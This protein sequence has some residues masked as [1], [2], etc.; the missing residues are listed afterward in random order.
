M[1]LRDG[2]LLFHGS[3]TAVEH[4]DLNQCAAGKDF[5]KGFYLTSDMNRAKSF[6]RSV[7]E[8][9]R[10]RGVIP[11]EQQFGFVSSYRFRMPPEDLTVHEFQTADKEWLW[12]IANNRRRRLASLLPQQSGR[13]SESD[14]VIGKV[15]N[16]NTNPVITTYLNGLYGDIQSEEAVDEAIRRLIPDHLVDQYCF[17]TERAINSLVFQEARKYV[18]K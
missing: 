14:I 8:R 18:I 12:F 1:K 2:M 5:G 9:A 16:D 4:I 13:V 10:A 7:L 11:I 3:Y 15:A 6:I 17:L